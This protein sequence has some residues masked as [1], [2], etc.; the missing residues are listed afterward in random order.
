M[1]VST[2]VMTTAPRLLA[3]RDRD[4]ARARRELDRIRQQVQQDLLDA[5]LIAA[6]PRQIGVG[7][8]FV[9]HQP[10]F[11]G[12]ALHHPQRR[13]EQLRNVDLIVRELQPAGVDLGKIEDVV[14]QGQKMRAA[15][16]MLVA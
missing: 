1:P 4:G 8:L 3:R 13:G 10:G 9:Q 7:D 6:Q 15:V 16:R 14:D 12:G 11:G 2:T 5:A